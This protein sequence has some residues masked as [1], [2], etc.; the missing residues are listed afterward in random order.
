MYL[1]HNVDTAQHV[2]IANYGDGSKNTITWLMIVF[3]NFPFIR[4]VAIHVNGTKNSVAS[5]ITQSTTFNYISQTCTRSYAN[6][7][8]VR[9]QKKIAVAK[10]VYASFDFV[11][12]NAKHTRS[13]NIWDNDQ[14]MIECIK[15][16]KHIENEILA[17]IYVNNIECLNKGSMIGL[18]LWIYFILFSICHSF[19]LSQYIRLLKFWYDW[20]LQFVYFDFFSSFG[21]FVMKWVFAVL[22]KTKNLNW[23][24]VMIYVRNY[25]CLM[26]S[27]STIFLCILREKYPFINNQVS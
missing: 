16:R 8:M 4:S 26:L 14:N 23:I 21:V 9:L 5:I 17:R 7:T 24:C 3:S 11:Q 27:H 2:I 22:Y 1:N 18:H 13:Q 6:I 20:E 15:Q 19:S 10:K 25:P 12:N